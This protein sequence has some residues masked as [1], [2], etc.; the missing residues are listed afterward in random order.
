MELKMVDAIVA[1]SV[2]SA[3]LCTSAA[4]I[5]STLC[6]N[7][8]NLKS[9]L[10]KLQDELKS[11]QLI[12]LQSEAK[13]NASERISASEHGAQCLIFDKYF[14]TVNKISSKLRNKFKSRLITCQNVNYF[15]EKL[16]N[17]TWE[18]VYHNTDVNSAF[19]KFL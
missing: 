16:S 17:E 4:N 13:S 2:S 1:F 18:E 5:N 10:Q 14:V 9:D 3:C 11:A 19:N 6:I 15:S 7:C 12:I 8:E